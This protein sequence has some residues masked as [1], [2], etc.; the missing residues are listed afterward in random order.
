MRV[1][2][3]FL[4]S[5]DAYDRVLK[6]VS[7]KVLFIPKSD[8]QEERER[9]WF[10]LGSE[11]LLLCLEKHGFCYQRF[12]DTN[13]IVDIRSESFEFFSQEE[14]RAWFYGYLRDSYNIVKKCNEIR[15]K[16]ANLYDSFEW[17]GAEKESLIHPTIVRKASRISGNAVIG[18]YHTGLSCVDD[19]MSM[20]NDITRESYDYVNRCKVMTDDPGQM[21]LFSNFIGFATN[22]DIIYIGC[23]PGLGWC[24]AAKY[25][26]YGRKVYCFDMLDANHSYVHAEHKKMKVTSWEDVAKNVP[27]GRYDFIWDLRSDAKEEFLTTI[28]SICDEIKLLNDI[29]RNMDL[30]RC[31]VKVNIRLANRYVYRSGVKFFIQPFT[32][33]R[34]RELRAVFDNTK[35][36]ISFSDDLPGILSEFYERKYIDEEVMY[37]NSFAM[38]YDMVDY[39]NEANDEGDLRIILFSANCNNVE[40]ISQIAERGDRVIMSYFAL[41]EDLQKNEFRF[42]ISKFVRFGYSSFDSRSIGVEK[43]EGLY[44]MSNVFNVEPYDEALLGESNVIKAV[45]E[46]IIL[47]GGLEEY[48]KLKFT[49]SR[50]FGKS[51]PKFPEFYSL[52][53]DHVSPSGHICRVAIGH[54]LGWCNLSQF[55]HKVVNDLLDLHTNADSF[56]ELTPTSTWHSIDEWVLG[57]EIAK[58]WLNEK[59]TDELKNLIELSKERIKST[60]NA[61]RGIEIFMMRKN[62]GILNVSFDCSSFERKRG[63]IPGSADSSIITAVFEKVLKKIKNEFPS[64]IRWLST[65]K[66]DDVWRYLVGKRVDARLRAFLFFYQLRCFRDGSV[67]NASEVSRLVTESFKDGLLFDDGSFYRWTAAVFGEG[68]DLNFPVWKDIIEGSPKSK[69]FRDLNDRFPLFFNGINDVMKNVVFRPLR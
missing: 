36:E 25:I 43:L 31:L 29:L 21:K 62:A 32:F 37:A 50:E 26:G 67:W 58:T 40:K 69:I 57:L 34:I 12:I 23:A 10:L 39:C 30:R 49:K 64:F 20:R 13:N 17:C 15:N 52:R 55:L 14:L 16:L 63:I 48:L 22:Y 24:E 27:P 9:L 61:K 7:P 8:K 2:V 56:M 19:H 4:V 60:K 44:F 59:M 11:V 51:F 28:D 6:L 47:S 18:G 68:Y 65:Y 66:S 46:R 33:G 42:P 1:K 41:D 54:W 5:T 38:R 3:G 45:L 35:E 53:D